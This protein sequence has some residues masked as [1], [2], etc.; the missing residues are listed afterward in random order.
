MANSTIFPIY[1]RSEYSGSTALKRF[2]SD[3]QRA[4]QA[5]K[6]EFAGVSKAVEGA[7]SRPRTAGGSLDLG[8]NEMRAALAAQQQIAIASREVATAT[9]AA[10]LAAGGFEGELGRAARAA[11]SLASAEERATEEMRQQIAA[12]DAVQAQMG[13]SAAASI[14]LADAHQRG[15]T[16]AAAQRGA[17]QNLGFQLNDVATQFAL[18]ASA[19][20][21]FASQGGQIVQVLQQMALNSANSGSAA[22]AASTDIDEFGNTV[23]DTADRAKD[24]GGR[25][26][27]VASFLAG[28]WGIALTTAAVALSPFIAKLFE[29]EEGGTAMR[30]ALD[31]ARFAADGMATAQGILGES[32]DLTTG[33]MR[34]QTEAA[35]NLARTQLQLAE[36]KARVAANEARSIVQAATQRQVVVG[37]RRVQVQAPGAPLAINPTTNIARRV[38]TVS[39]AA[40]EKALAGDVRGALD[41]LKAAV[42]SGKTT[43]AIYAET[44]TAI[45][46]L[47]AETENMQ[48]FGEALKALD[49][50]RAALRQFL[51]PQRGR[52]GGGGDVGRA[53]REAEQLADFGAQAAERIARLNERFDE[54]PRLIDQAAQATR[55]LDKIITELGEKKP[56]NFAAMI[57]DAE[58]AKVTVED[59]LLRPFREL[60]A[61]SEQRL[62]IEGLLAQGR[63]DEAAVLEEVVRLERQIG[64]L[65]AEQRQ[66]VE[67]TVRAEVERTR[68]LRVQQRLFE[69][70][71]DVVGQVQRSLTDLLSGRGGDFFGDFRRALQDLQGQRLFEDI[72]GQA[73]RDIEE[74][75]RG[76]TPQGRANAAYAAEVE[77][78]ASATQAVGEAALSL[79][80]AFDQAFAIVSGAASRSVA[81]AANDSGAGVGNIT[82]TARKGEEVRIAR[83]SVSDLASRI[84]TGIGASI[85]AELE[86]VFG[87]RFASVFGDI[88]GGAIA[89]KVTGGNVGA[90]LGGAK[91]LLDSGVFG[92]A[93]GISAALGKAGEGAAVGSQVAALSGLLGI[94]GSKTGAQI[95]GALGSVL[96]FP[97]G[98]I[99][100]A[101]A[102]NLLGGLLKGTPRGS[103]TI[104]GVG[105]SL[106]VTGISGN[107][108]SLRDAAGNLADS[109]LESVRRIAEQLGGDVN[110]SAGRVSIGQRKDSLRVDPSGRGAT[111]IGNGAIDFGQDAEAAIAFAVR[112]L[113]QDGVITGL[114]A[115]EQRL[116]RAGSDIEASIRDVLTFRSVFDRL[117]EIKDPVGAAIDA[118]T[119]EFDQFRD[120][121]ARAGADA[122]EL[123]SLEE[124]YGLERARAI[125]DA[126]SRIVGS[127]RGLLDDLRIGDSGLSLRTRRG[128]ALGQFDAL[129]TR[130]QAGDSTAFD[131]FADISKQLLEIERQLFGSTQAYFDRLGQITALTETA[132]AGQSNVASIGSA[133]IAPADDRAA[134]VRSIDVQTDAIAG[135]LDVLNSNFVALASRLERIDGGRAGEMWGGRFSP[136]SMRVSNF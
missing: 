128:N 80:G 112:D 111:K 58:K 39:A 132:I 98:N 74:E 21:I 15:A 35:N 84:A 122:T 22:G 23:T 102:G 32:I 47:G 115:S 20:Q 13:K 69:A 93:K 31:N 107:R 81:G 117:K 70:Q 119:R 5:A 42:D 67:D 108:G 53:A 40:A 105:G 95:G 78:T 65:T 7:L 123:A 57:E 30:E 44:A 89:G 9:K 43:A 75:L 66:E 33:R 135:R 126:T 2:E 76:N 71:L 91:G 87:P 133:A 6:R 19:V 55:E 14:A 61:E 59:A 29:G 120:V 45:A 52:S 51:K 64:T 124:L 88:V 136:F 11:L 82:V 38:P 118:V 1:I 56:A 79:A 8:V 125:E 85:G 3:A 24:M 37:T 18:G 129:A 104:G 86:D 83:V 25:I 94:K 116:I 99:V 54:Q 121:F 114:K 100:G 73:F 16:S 50:D 17:M 68:E 92:N 110:A 28:P 134:V 10:A 60:R 96:P 103:A 63:D 62:A 72:F 49:G 90:V 109:V 34:E 27:A 131:D 127:L 97:G 46:N 36:V 26:G 101:I 106:G 113:I 130:V 12:L 41:D 48:R 77:K 4:A